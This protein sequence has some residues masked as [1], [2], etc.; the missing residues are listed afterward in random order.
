MSNFICRHAS[1]VVRGGIRYHN[2]L[3]LTGRVKVQE[4][5]S[6]VDLSVTSPVTAKLKAKATRQVT[7]EFEIP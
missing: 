2:V 3:N 1:T 6:S 5:V 7:P 4:S